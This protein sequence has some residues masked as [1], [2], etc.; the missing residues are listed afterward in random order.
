MTEPKHDSLV[1][2]FTAAYIPRKMEASGILTRT[3]EPSIN[4]PKG[5][6]L[7][8]ERQAR[9]DVPLWSGLVQYFPDA[10]AV[11]ARVSHAGSKQHH[12][13]L[14][15]HW[16]KSKS[17]DHHDCLLRHLMES[18]SLDTDGM[19]HSGKVAWRALAILQLELENAK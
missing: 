5:H 14:P 7:P 1:E 18:G 2:S 9:K 10:L 6:T 11:V 16:D 3:S 12:P 8:T 19:P 15:L 13:E 17:T 4:V